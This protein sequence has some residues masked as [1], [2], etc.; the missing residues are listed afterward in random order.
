M[1]A[2]VGNIIG[3]IVVSSEE[4]KEA[5]VSHAPLKRRVVKK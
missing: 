5:P 2:E 4:E 1:S 3:D